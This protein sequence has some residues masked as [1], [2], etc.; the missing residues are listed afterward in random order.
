MLVKLTVQ[1]GGGGGSRG[2]AFERDVART[3]LDVFEYPVNPG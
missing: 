1:E 3:E 2:F